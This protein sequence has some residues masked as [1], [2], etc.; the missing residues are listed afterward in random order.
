MTYGY[1]AG[2]A[3]SLSTATVDDF[4]LDLLNRLRSKRTPEV[5]R[6]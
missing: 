6:L 3:F 1:N 2:A 4:A 5:S